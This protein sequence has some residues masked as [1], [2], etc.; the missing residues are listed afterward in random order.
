MDRTIPDSEKRHRRLRRLI[1]WGCALLALAAGGILLGHWLQDSVH[2]R[3]L[4]FCTADT[5]T[6]ESAVTTNGRIVPAFEQIIVS[7]VA[8]RILEVYAHEGDAVDEGTPLLRLDT[9]AARTDWQR[10]ADELAMKQSEIHSQG[11]TDETR[12]TDL[13]M[14]I[15]TKELTVE[16][17]L[18]EYRSEQRLDSIG[19][20]TGERVSQAR[21]AWQTAELELQQMRRQLDN[22]RR[23]ARATAASKHLEENISAR[24]LAEAARTLEEAR[25]AAPRKG[26]LTFLNSNVGATV[27]AGERLAVLSDL[28][29]FKAQGELPE[30]HGD[31]LTIGAPV[32]V[33]VGSRRYSGHVSQRN[34][35]SSAGV[36]TFTALLDSADAPGLRSGIA[37]H[38]SLIY[39]EKPDVVRIKSGSFFKGAGEYY[40]YV[41]TS[42]SRLERRKVRL[43]DSNPDYIEVVTGLKEGDVVVTAGIE[44]TRSVIPIKD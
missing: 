41:R 35:Q 37:A 10:R 30:G 22:E 12:L 24:Q 11:L 44:S 14:R 19:S 17:L 32:M 18:A 15:R 26:T 29:S 31:K 4:T 36:I 38:V 40:L 27:G 16:Q 43:G 3:D 7:P 9:E 28:S 8:T 42:D 33:R 6:I 23:I 13:E 21:L 2:S 34:A 39:D 1:P 25:V 5:G 20:G